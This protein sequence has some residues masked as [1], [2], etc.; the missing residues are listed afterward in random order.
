MAYP[1]L[2]L[3]ALSAA[4]EELVQKMYIRMF[5]EDKLMQQLDEELSPPDQSPMADSLRA[6]GATESNKVQCECNT[7]SEMHAVLQANGITS[8]QL[9]NPNDYISCTPEDIHPIFRFENFTSGLPGDLARNAWVAMA[10]ALTLATKWITTPEVQG[11]WHRLSFGEF[12]TAHGKTYLARSPIEDDPS[13][14]STCFA[15]ILTSMA[16]KLKFWWVPHELP[17]HETQLGCSSRNAFVSIYMLCASLG[18]EVSM[19]S[20]Y[21]WSLSDVYEYDGYIG[22]SCKILHNLLSPKS[23]AR[24]DDCTM[25]RL[26]LHIAHVLCHELCHALYGWRCLPHKEPYVF[27]SDPMAEVGLSWSQ[28]VLGADM[29]FKDDGMRFMFC[30]TYKYLYSLPGLSYIINDRWVEAWFRKGTWERIEEVVRSNLLKLP[31]TAS[32]S[33][34]TVWMAAR[35]V[36]DSFYD[37]IYMDREVIW[38]EDAV[39]KEDA[40]PDGVPLE[41]WYDQVRK[42]EMELAVAAG[43]DENLFQEAEGHYAKRTY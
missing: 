12:A 4:D 3:P 6:L 23:S 13:M 26:Q 42:R 2:T 22:L 38:P 14:A 7:P 39:V 16:N 37:C 9:G 43:F 21:S 41:E 5:T 30:R 25:M 1:V 35:V 36:G 29:H 15:N 28:N 34:P 27:L 40:P 17:G 11:F 18:E 32:L 31:N 19:R 10:P 24:L 8:T 20:G 33:G